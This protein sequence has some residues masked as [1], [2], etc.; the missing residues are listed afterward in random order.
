MAFRFTAAY[1]EFIHDEFV[2]RQMVFD[3]PINPQDY[4]DKGADDA[5]VNRPF[6]TYA[7]VDLHPTL[8]QKAAAIFHSVACSHSFLNGN[9]R[10]AVMVLDMFL[11][12]NEYLLLMNNQDI[13]E[14]AKNTVQANMKGASLDSI[15][16]LLTERIEGE[17][18]SFAIL[19]TLPD[20]SGQIRSSALARSYPG[21]LSRSYPGNLN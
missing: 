1:V 15:L 11:T 5:A 8:F 6:Q 21:V 20:E 14:L 9:K 2:A 19:Q 4:R 16:G 18:I 17:S 7:G 12:A 10:T 3:E 13:Y